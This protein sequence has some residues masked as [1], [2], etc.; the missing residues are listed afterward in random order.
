MMER[1]RF[2]AA[3]AVDVAKGPFSRSYYVVGYPRS[4][5]TWVASML[6][7]HL[8]L[9]KDETVRPWWR[10]VSARVFH[11]H[12][13]IPIPWIRRRTLYVLRDGRDATVSR[14]FR[15]VHHA[16]ARFRRVAE[17]ALDAPLEPR[18][19]ADNLPLYIDFLSRTRYASLP[20]EAHLKAWRRWPYPTVRFEDLA[21]DTAQAFA[22]A[23]TDLTQR[24]PAVEG[25]AD[26]VERNSF[27]SMAGRAPGES[28]DA[29][30]YRKGV[31]G[32]WRNHFNREAAVVFDRRAGRM[33]VEAGYEPDRSWVGRSPA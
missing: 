5:T 25:F 17:R 1:L 3:V 24:S 20:Y 13:M 26:V 10:L 19:I 29:S 22:A 15:H 23:V 27:E 4:G 16:G 33:L 28:N 12:R 32:D 18:S 8:R 11:T 9:A 14:Y 31:V 2:W 6:S 21:Q 30:F 7:D